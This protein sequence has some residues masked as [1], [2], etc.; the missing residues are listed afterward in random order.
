MAEAIGLYV[1]LPWCVR[2]CPYCDFN[3][4]ALRQP[5]EERA[6]V[7]ALMRDLEQQLDRL[8]APPCVSSIFIGGGTPSLFSGEAV[9]NLLEGIR[10]RT[11]CLP[12][13]EITLEANP[14]TVEQARFGQYRQAG[15]TRLSLG[16]Q[17][18]DDGMLAAL[19][20]IHDG[21]QAR[22]AL[23]AAFKAGFE[24]V[25]GD[26]MFGLPQQ[27]R[28]QALQDVQ[29]LLQ[30][31]VDHISLYQLTIE[32][33]TLFAHQ[34][35]PL[36]GHD[37]LADM[38]EQL[39]RELQAAGFER[40]EVSAFAR[41]GSQCR[42]NHNYWRFGDYLGL[43]AGAHGKWRD[44]EGRTVRTLRPRHPQAYLQAVGAGQPVELRPVEPE[45]V[46]F[47]FML[48]ALRL[49]DGVEEPRFYQATGLPLDC[50]RQT[51]RKLRRLG[52][53]RPDR[54]ACT[55]NGFAFLDDVIAE[56]LP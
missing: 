40:Y 54:L 39:I 27:N 24:H 10:Q 15:V 17:S 16:L 19:G 42:H 50:C 5:L 4:H 56:F 37:A 7:Q 3:S 44:A 49:I 48:N 18:F 21:R 14:G 25:N 1:H 33:N 47:E 23:D 8:P 6:Y 43:G 45:S 35:P 22:A 38:H 12:D 51:L 32:P 52:L 41:P 46:P 36:P 34:P 53:M 31:P 13:C 9:H 2:K 26:L 29:T 11:N 55:D 30:W 20:R 28:Q